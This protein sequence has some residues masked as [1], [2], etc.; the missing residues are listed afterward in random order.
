MALF[1]YFTK[2]EW[3]IWLFSMT[4]I[5]SSY[6]FFNQANL[7]ALA[8][9]LIGAT[10]LIFSAKANP[11]GQGLIIIFSVIYAYLSLRNHYYGE[12]LTYFLLTLPMA[13][14]ALFSW[15]S[16]PFEGKKSQVLISRLKVKD[17]YILAFFTFLVTIVF[18]FILDIFHTSFLLVATL[19]IATSFVATFL[20]Y[21]RSPFY[22][23]FFA[24][25]DVVLILLWLL[26]VDA[27]PS[28]YS[29]AICFIIFL[30]NDIY[31]FFNWVKLQKGQELT[32]KKRLE[33]K[34][35]NF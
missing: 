28:H 21:K 26:E 30:I 2:L 4:S 32:L 6:I 22:A 3:L 25:N 14:F 27:D 9:S 12:V 11:L 19:S 13:I 7:L 23:L 8:A 18:Y 29:I 20:S 16:H 17:I 31:T 10:S 34:D 15:L 24:L 5:I 35:L 33:Q 1:K